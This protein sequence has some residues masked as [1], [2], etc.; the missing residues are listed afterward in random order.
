MM[1]DLLVITGPNTGGKTVSLKTVGL[2]TL[3]GQAGLHIPAFE[4]QRTGAFSTRY[5]QISE[6]SRVLSRVLSTFSSHMTTIVSIFEKVDT[7][8]PGSL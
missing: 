5:M 3:M 7:V 4:R 6:M 8:F 1:F 2:F